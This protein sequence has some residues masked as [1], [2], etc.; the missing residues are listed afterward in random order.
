[1][2]SQHFRQYKNAAARPQDG[3][4]HRIDVGPGGE[5]LIQ[6]IEPYHGKRA[7]A[8]PDGQERRFELGAEAEPVSDRTQ[9]DYH[10][11]HG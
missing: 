2:L 8:L 6:A 7:V 10:S 4:A 3:L 9:P 11:S 1:M 5:C